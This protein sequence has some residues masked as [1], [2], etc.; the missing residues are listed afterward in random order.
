MDFSRNISRC[1]SRGAAG[2]RVGEFSLGPKHS[3]FPPPW[4]ALL[5]LTTHKPLFLAHDPQKS[6]NFQCHSHRNR[7]GMLGRWFYLLFPPNWELKGKIFKC[8]LKA[9][10]C[11]GFLIPFTWAKEGL[12]R[13]K[14]HSH[15]MKSWSWCLE[16]SDFGSFSFPH[17][18]AEFPDHNRGSWWGCFVPM[19]NNRL[20][21][22]NKWR[23]H[24]R[25][26]SFGTAPLPALMVVLCVASLSTGF[27]AIFVITDCFCVV[28]GDWHKAVPVSWEMEQRYWKL[29]WK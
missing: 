26:G 14:S 24:E 3:C 25:W 12:I 18:L 7:A 10:L 11:E 5:P 9:G 2:Q 23:F 6:T 16:P 21:P 8:F 4:G 1:W 15:Q 29:C 19:M 17:L 28:F 27:A 20:L 13:G 22:L